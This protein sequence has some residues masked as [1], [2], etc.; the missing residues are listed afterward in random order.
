MIAVLFNKKN[1]R[2]GTVD[3]PDDCFI[4]EYGGAFFARS[5]IEVITAN[6]GGRAVAYEQS[7]RFHV[8]TLKEP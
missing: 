4:I 2:L 3:C 1:V 6:G 5:E 7:D 8:L